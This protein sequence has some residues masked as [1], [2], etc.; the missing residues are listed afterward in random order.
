MTT[1]YKGYQCKTWFDEDR[2]FIQIADI[3][4]FITGECLFTDNI[5]NAFKHLV[6]DYIAT[7]EEQQ[8]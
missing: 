3:S 2:I 5:E 4:D 8:L 6:D 7:C 1:T